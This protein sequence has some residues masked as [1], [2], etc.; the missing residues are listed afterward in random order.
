MR[1]W[2]FGIMAASIPT[3]APAAVVVAVP[4]SEL[5]AR[6]DTIV[7]GAVLSTRTVMNTQ[8]VIGTQA[9]LQVYKALRGAQVGDVLLLQVPGGTLDNG[10]KASSPGSPELKKG[11]MVFAFLETS[12]EVRRPLGLSYGLLRAQPDGH[13]SFRLYRDTTDLTMIAPGGG[14]VDTRIVSIK[15]VSLSEMIARVDH[16]LRELNIPAPGTVRP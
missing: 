8:G 6:A 15:D 11:D 7:F 10:L 2:L 5:V 16:R 14:P 12:G 3:L 1:A 4:E 13:G 9:D